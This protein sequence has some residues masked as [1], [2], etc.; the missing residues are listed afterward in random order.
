MD[1]LSSR[2]G[3]YLAIACVMVLSRYM[4]KFTILEL[5]DKLRMKDHAEYS[6]TITM[7]LFMNYTIVSVVIALSVQTNLFGT[8]MADA[9]A[10]F[11]RIEPIHNRLKA[12]KQ[13]YDYSPQWYADYGFQ[14]IMN[15]LVI[16]ILPY[17][18]IP[19][20]HLISKKIRKLSRN[21]SSRLNKA[22]KDEFL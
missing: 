22:S 16:I 15:Y 19:L 17:S 20:M 7:H 3:I 2:V 21:S 10:S 12:L 6:H 8:A 4:M 11:L 9:L 13:Y 18:I 5:A 1:Q 14:L